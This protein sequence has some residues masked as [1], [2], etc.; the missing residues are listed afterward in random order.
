MLLFHFVFAVIVLVVVVLLV[1][2]V[3]VLGYLLVGFEL[4]SSLLRF[5]RRIFLVFCY[6]CR[7]RCH[8]RRGGGFSFLV[9]SFFGGGERI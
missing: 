1:L 6:R 5:F 2:G 9:H 7:C 4:P 8:C 3:V